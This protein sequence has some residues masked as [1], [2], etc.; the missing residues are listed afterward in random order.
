MNKITIREIKEALKDS[1]FRATL[2]S[3]LKEDIRK[4]EQNPNCPC[5]L[6]IYKN[7]LKYAA[8]N[9]KD[10]FPSKEVSQDVEPEVTW[11]VI[12][13]SVEELEAK[14]NSILPYQRLLTVARWENQCTVIINEPLDT[15]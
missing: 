10:Y 11:T 7:V 4:Y 5:N 9:L 12:N 1:K 3:E 6:A 8:A 13:C 2:P 15:E 14:L